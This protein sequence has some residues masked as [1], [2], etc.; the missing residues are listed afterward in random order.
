[1]IPGGNALE[2][3]GGKALEMSDGGALRTP[4]G[5]IFQW[6]LKLGST[7]SLSGNSLS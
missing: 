3:P 5:N 7:N 1:M 2:I 4:G 6:F